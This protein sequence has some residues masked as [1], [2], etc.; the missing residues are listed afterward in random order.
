MQS[1]KAHFE[2]LNK[3]ELLKGTVLK[4][5]KS[6]TNLD[7]DNIVSEFHHLHSLQRGIYKPAATNYVLSCKVTDDKDNYGTQ[8]KWID[9]SKTDFSSIKLAPPSKEKDVQKELDISA[10]R[11]NLEFNLPTGII[12]K[13]NPGEYLCLGLGI[14]TEEDNDG[15]FIIEP[16]NFQEI[17]ETL[18]FSSEISIP[19]Y[20]EA[21]VTTKRRIG[22]VQFRNALLSLNQCCEIC[23]VSSNHT[24]ASHIKPWASAENSERLDPN[25]GLLLCPNHDHLFD[26]GFISFSNKGKIIF[27]PQLIDTDRISFGLSDTIELNIDNAKAKYLKFH[28]DHIL[29]K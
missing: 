4:G 11:H 25:N 6:I 8:I 2:I 7:A 24:R 10:M 5:K 29:K 1:E 13:L 14:F 12:Y 20:T 9:E 28:R 3:F 17:K 26:K 22:Q 16:F 18:H 23:G 27:S 15:N 21:I 19:E